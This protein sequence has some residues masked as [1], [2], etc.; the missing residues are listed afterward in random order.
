MGN[1]AY[2]WFF[3]SA[4]QKHANDRKIHLLRWVKSLSVLFWSI[5]IKLQRERTG[6]IHDCKPSDTAFWL[7]HRTYFFGTKLNFMEVSRW[8]FM[9]DFSSIIS[10][11]RG[12]SE[13]TLRSITV[14]ALHVYSDNI[15]KQIVAFESLGSTGWN[16]SSFL[17][18]FKK[19]RTISPCQA[20]FSQVPVRDFQCQWGGREK[21]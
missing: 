1:P 4:P 14:S 19:V 16:W 7:W 17:E 2:D 13:D 10:S 15:F 20:R 8:A 6:R 3:T 12:L 9:I 5:L 18:Y 11:D 21:L